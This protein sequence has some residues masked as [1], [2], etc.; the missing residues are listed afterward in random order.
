MVYLGVNGKGLVKFLE[1]LLGMI[2]LKILG[3]IGIDMV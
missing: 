3:V 2:Y 1:F